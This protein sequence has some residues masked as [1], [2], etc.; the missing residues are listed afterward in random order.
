MLPNELYNNKNEKIRLDSFLSSRTS[1]LSRTQIQ[2]LIKNGSILVDEFLVKPSFMLKGNEC[3]TVNDI[4]QINKDSG[5]V[6]Q[7]I[8]INVIYEDEDIIDIPVYNDPYDL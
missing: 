1:E 5:I 6:K 8:P 3:I 7:D 4:H 2:K